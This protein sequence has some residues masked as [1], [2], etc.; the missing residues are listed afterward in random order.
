VS[1]M[2]VPRDAGATTTIV[3]D[4]LTFN[5]DC[6]L[7][8]NGCTD[9][10]TTFGTVTAVLTA[11]DPGTFSQAVNAYLDI[12]VQMNGDTKVDAIAFNYNVD[13]S[14]AGHFLFY[15]VSPT[16]QPGGVTFTD[17]TNDIDDSG[18]LPNF[19]DPGLKFDLLVDPSQNFINEPLH[20]YLALNNGDITLETLHWTSHG[21]G[22]N[23]LPTQP[24]DAWV[25]MHWQACAEVAAACEG[26]GSLFVGALP[27]TVVPEP[28][29]L[30][31]LGSGLAGLA[32]WRRRKQV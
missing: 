32:L 7:G 16:D 11:G 21:G 10:G 8:V 31:L 30:L 12:T 25:G 2:V 19:S 9:A 26:P 18:N 23:D 1:D 3:G 24:N 28:A 20:F 17:S 6:L 4:T 27:D 29:S 14:P 13:G 5:I 22:P 15:W